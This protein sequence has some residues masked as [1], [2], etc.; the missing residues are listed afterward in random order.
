MASQILEKIIIGEISTHNCY[1]AFFS[2]LE[3]T[4]LVIAT[5]NAVNQ[6]QNESTLRA[7]TLFYFIHQKTRCNILAAKW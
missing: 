6:N 1:M 5:T 7:K 3:L 2:L 4:W